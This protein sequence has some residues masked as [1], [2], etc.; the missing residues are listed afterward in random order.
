MVLLRPGVAAHMWDAV[1]ATLALDILPS[2]IAS[3]V[4]GL[5]DFDD[6]FVVG[7][8]ICYKYRFHFP[9]SNFFF[10]LFSCPEQR[11]Q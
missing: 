6:L 4:I 2:G 5:E 8:V 1:E 7:L 9:V 3:L 10:F 11:A